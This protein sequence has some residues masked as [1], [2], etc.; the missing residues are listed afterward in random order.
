M[1]DNKSIAASILS[2]NALF[3]RLESARSQEKLEQRKIESAV[4]IKSVEHEITLECLELAQKLAAKLKQ[5]SEFPESSRFTKSSALMAESLVMLLDE[6]N[7]QKPV[8]SEKSIVAHE[9]KVN[10][11]TSSNPSVEFLPEI[12]FDADRGAPFLNL[13]FDLLDIPPFEVEESTAQT[14][15]TKSLDEVPVAVIPVEKLEI[16][17]P[18]KDPLKISGPIF[19]E[20]LDQWRTFLI[21]NR[22]APQMNKDNPEETRLYVWSDRIRIAIA[23][24]SARGATSQSAFPASSKQAL[25]DANFFSRKHIPKKPY[26]AAE[27][28]SKLG[29]QG[30]KLEEIRD[31][32]DGLK[33]S[34]PFI[35][36]DEEVDATIFMASRNKSF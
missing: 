6:S 35:K 12:D 7:S 16:D 2:S 32:A 28:G 29:I 17:K 18:A 23:K 10:E 11:K 3:K 13:S 4:E 30:K 14:K 36:S 33:L 1:D 25:T 8:D 31:I 22:R 24:M 21:K 26:S 27:F 5:V 19:E 9:I 34:A 15:S 20:S